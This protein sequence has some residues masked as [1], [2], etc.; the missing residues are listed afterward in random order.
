[1]FRAASISRSVRPH[2]ITD[3]W[4]L[5]SSAN[6]SPMIVFSVMQRRLVVLK[7]PNPARQSWLRVI[8]VGVAEGLA[9][10]DAAAALDFHVLGDGVGASGVDRAAA[11]RA[12]DFVADVDL[13]RRTIGHFFCLLCSSGPASGRRFSSWFV[14]RPLWRAPSSACS[15]RTRKSIRSRLV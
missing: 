15:R 14:H 5:R 10:A 12:R 9:A 2:L 6:I 3:W 7:T 4:P 11:A 13:R 1:M 8:L